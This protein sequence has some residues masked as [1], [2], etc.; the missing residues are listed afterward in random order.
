MT[1]DFEGT[2][3]VQPVKP[4]A[5]R[6]KDQGAQCSRGSLGVSWRPGMVSQEI[7]DH[8]CASDRSKFKF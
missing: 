4:E 5:V 8:A 3:G 2:V 1:L 7:G 6:T